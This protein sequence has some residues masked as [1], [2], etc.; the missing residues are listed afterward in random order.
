MSSFIPQELLDSRMKALKKVLEDYEAFK[1]TEER[2]SKELLVSPSVKG[3]G[4]WMPRAERE[5]ERG[6]GKRRG[7]GEGGGEGGGSSLGAHFL[8]PSYSNNL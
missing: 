6:R 8:S 2:E 3:I 7:R 1:S 5:R 4:L